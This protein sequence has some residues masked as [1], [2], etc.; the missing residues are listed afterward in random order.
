[1]KEILDPNGNNNLINRNDINNAE[2]AIKINFAHDDL[3]EKIGIKKLNENSKIE[4]DDKKFG[5]N[6]DLEYE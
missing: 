5:E 2:E 3:D 6:I 4:D 1:M